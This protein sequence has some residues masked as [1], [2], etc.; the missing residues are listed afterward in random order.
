MARQRLPLIADD[1]DQREVANCRRILSD[2]IPTNWLTAVLLELDTMG[3]LPPADDSQIDTAVGVVWETL[4]P[5]G[6]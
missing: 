6:G 2:D 1:D 3:E 4:F 5:P